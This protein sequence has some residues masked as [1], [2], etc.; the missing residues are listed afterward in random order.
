MSKQWTP[1]V[2]DT[3]TVIGGIPS[4]KGIECTIIDYAGDDNRILV[5][6]EFFKG[7]YNM[8]KSWI[9]PI[10]A[11]E[12]AGDDNPQWSG[13]ANETWLTEDERRIKSLGIGGFVT[14]W[15]QHGLFTTIAALRAENARLRVFV[16]DVIN[17]APADEPLSLSM[18]VLPA[19]WSFWGAG[20][21]ARELLRQ[22]DEADN[23]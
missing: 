21:G 14:K 11:P 6:S 19:A 13:E 5:Q 3:V 7:I 17:N 12:P 2:G 4:F 15:E 1:K 10:T 9:A 18:E 8:S 22:L 20:S 16:Q 23:A